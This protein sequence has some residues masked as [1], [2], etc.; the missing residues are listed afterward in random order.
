MN[1]IMMEK[2]NSSQIDSIGY[3]DGTLVVQFKSGGGGP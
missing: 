3:A 1:N 2:V